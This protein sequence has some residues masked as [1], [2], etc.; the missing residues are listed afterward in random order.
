M[1]ITYEIYIFETDPPH[2]ETNSPDINQ[3]DLQILEFALISI[4]IHQKIVD[5]STSSILKSNSTN[6]TSR[7]ISCSD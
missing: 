4:G 7:S 2:F 3:V 6:I 1:N 5:N